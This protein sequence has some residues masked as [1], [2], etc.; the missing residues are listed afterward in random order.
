MFLNVGMRAHNAANNINVS[1]NLKSER[2][3]YDYNSLQYYIINLYAS[4]LE[5]KSIINSSYT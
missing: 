3:W 4:I 1:I 5:A 2:D